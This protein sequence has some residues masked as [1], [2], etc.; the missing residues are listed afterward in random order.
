MI[1]I[2]VHRI[3]KLAHNNSRSRTLHVDAWILSYQNIYIYASRTF[4]H[5]AEPSVSATP[6][7]PDVHR[8]LN[9]NSN[10]SVITLNSENFTTLESR[11]L[12]LFCNGVC[13]VD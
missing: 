5:S 4:A 9:K 7:V 13:D 11:F 3:R 2:H 10:V 12:F 1:T 8:V 6:D